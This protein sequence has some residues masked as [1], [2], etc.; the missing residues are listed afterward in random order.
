MTGQI[1]LRS[2]TC[3]AC[4]AE[5]L[6]Q[7]D[8]FSKQIFLALLGLQETEVLSSSPWENSL[9]PSAPITSGA[10]TSAGQ[11]AAKAGLSHRA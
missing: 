10:Q 11:R 9:V 1:N 3:K 5:Q 7:N 4:Y 2:L 8:S 6:Y